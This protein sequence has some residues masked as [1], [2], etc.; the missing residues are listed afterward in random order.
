[1]PV[2][3]FQCTSCGARFDRSQPAAGQHLPECPAGHRTVRRVYTAPAVVF[4][5]PGFYS[6]DNRRHKGETTG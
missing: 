6:T 3:S 4:K 1:M 5:G 2:Y